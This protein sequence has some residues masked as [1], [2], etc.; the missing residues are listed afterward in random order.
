MKTTSVFSKNV[1][2]K[3]RLIIN[4]GGTSSSKTYSILQILLLICLKYENKLI[5]VVSESFPHLRKGAMRDF[6]NILKGEGLYS[7]DMH[8]MTN[9]SYIIGTCTVEFFSADNMDKVRGPR[10]DYLYVN[11]CNNISYDT[12]LQ[13]EVRTNER[14]YLDYNPTHEFWVH[15]N[16]LNSTEYVGGFDYTYIQ[17]TYKHN[18]FLHPNIVRSIEKQRNI[19]PRWFKVFGLGETGTL[20]GLI[21]ETFQTCIDMPLVDNIFYGL[22]FGFTNDVTA[23]VEVCIAGGEIWVDELIY[24]TAL[25]NQEIVNLFKSLGISKSAEIIADS[26]EMKSIEEI[27]R[28][29][30]N[31]KP[32]IKGPDSVKA[33]I[34]VVQNYPINITKRS[35]NTIKEIRNYQWDKDKDGKWLNKPVDYMNHSMDAIRY[36]IFTRQHKPS[37]KTLSYGSV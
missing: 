10:R 7:S 16:I 35:I 22:D 1:K 3:T 25:T 18:E 20:E 15:E 27:R 24:Q 19:N 21:Y 36:P 13:L 12:Y 29:G 33:G 37:S 17:S 9:N 26:A 6:E 31:I 32:A 8:D 28:A 30:F 14:V 4:Q 23:L 2:A 11:E 34:G 5:S